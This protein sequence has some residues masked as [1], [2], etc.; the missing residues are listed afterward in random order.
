MTTGKNIN[1]AVAAYVTIEA[2]FKLY[3]YKSKLRK[4]VLY[5]DTDSVVYIQN[6]DEHSKVVTGD[7]VGDLTDELEEFGSGT[8][9]EGF[10][11]G[12]T[13]NMHFLY[14]PTRQENN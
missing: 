10:V 1:V 13:Q 4:S 3:E 9:I 7:Y 6:E 12:G 14:F 2:R 8:Y 5:C 11:S